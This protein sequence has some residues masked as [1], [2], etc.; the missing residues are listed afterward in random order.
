MGIN[1]YHTRLTSFYFLNET[2]MRIILNKWDRVGMGAINPKPVPLSFL[3]VSALVAMSLGFHEFPPCL[4]PQV[5]H[6]PPRYI[7]L[8]YLVY[9]KYEPPK[10]TGFKLIDN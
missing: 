5:V 4:L 2:G 3:V 6:A 10:K 8:D 9:V 7:L 1:F